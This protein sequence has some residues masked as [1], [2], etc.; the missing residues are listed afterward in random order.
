MRDRTTSVRHLGTLLAA[1]LMLGACALA[2]ALWSSPRSKEADAL[3]RDPS[4]DAVEAPTALPVVARQAQES[5]ETIPAVESSPA[6]SEPEARAGTPAAARDGS[7][8]LSGVVRTE[9]GEV[10][11][12][13]VRARAFLTELSAA[14]DAE[15][16][17]ELV[18]PSRQSVVVTVLEPGFVLERFE[19]E[20]LDPGSRVSVDVVLRR[21]YQVRGRVTDEQ[22]A[23]IA[24]AR[25]LSSA[26]TD[27][28]LSDSEGRYRLDHLDPRSPASIRVHHRDFAA[29]IVEV[30]P[31]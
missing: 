8:T 27:E 12:A 17:Y 28:H 23:P 14:C 7:A 20:P 3:S 2:I 10:L 25:L 24:G 31:R 15:G 22:G 16:G 18:L 21:A 13:T 19:F 4:E 6:K 11:R 9:S 26:G 5:T 1:F 30:P 29:A